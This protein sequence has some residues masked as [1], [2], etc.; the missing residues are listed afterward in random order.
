VVQTAL[1][2]SDE[3]TEWIIATS[4]GGNDQ[5][6]ER[7]GALI[8]VSAVGGS[9]ALLLIFGLLA[10]VIA[11]VLWVEILF[12]NV[13]I[14]ILVAMAPIAAAGTV[15]EST[16]GWWT[17]A[18]S[19]LIQ[20][21]LLKPV[22]ALCFAIGFS[23]FGA[24]SD[25][26]GVIAGFVTLGLAAFAWPLLARFMTFTE[27]GHGHSAVT[28]LLGATAGAMAGRR[29]G[30]PAS[31]PSATQGSNYTLA[32]ERQND[33]SAVT[34]ATNGARAGAG[35]AG[36][37]LALVGSGALAAAG[38]AATAGTALVGH[39][40]RQMTSAS[41]DS[42]LGHVTYPR[43]ARGHTPGRF[44]ALRPNGHSSAASSRPVEGAATTGPPP[45][46]PAVGSAGEWEQ[47]PP[48]QHRAEPHHPSE[49]QEQERS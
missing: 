43:G 48:G 13:A 6:E 2:A 19:A 49:S 37:K 10:V 31:G 1:Y 47:H 39:A 35:A 34:H 27:G 9:P 41:A 45:A 36:S 26:I 4:L 44:R 46:D 14:V 38:A 33:S 17:K 15:L 30:A 16:S 11:F 24:A 20:L 18:R 3:I 28:G 42:G 12:R 21:I 40:E 7:L 23:T 29:L 8:S 22:I 5:L 25:L 32:L